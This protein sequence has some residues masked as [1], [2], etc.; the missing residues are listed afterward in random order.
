MIYKTIRRWEIDTITHTCTITEH[1]SVLWCDTF[2]LKFSS[3][4]PTNQVFEKE[5]RYVGGGGGSRGEG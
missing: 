5:E 2:L 1:L 4:Y 3:I